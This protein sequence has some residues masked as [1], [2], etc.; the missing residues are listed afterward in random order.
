[1][2]ER[3][4]IIDFAKVR[5]TS[6]EDYEQLLDIIDETHIEEEVVWSLKENIG[7]K[8]EVL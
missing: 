3:T 7:E 8:C 4:I 5:I 1:M 2:Q 6:K